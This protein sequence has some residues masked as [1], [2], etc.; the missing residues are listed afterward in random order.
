MDLSYFIRYPSTTIG[1][2]FGSIKRLWCWHA[3]ES[4]EVSYGGVI[5]YGGVFS[6]DKEQIP[7]SFRPY[8]TFTIHIRSSNLWT[9][10][11]TKIQKDNYKEVKGLRKEG[12]TYKQISDHFNEVGRK[13]TRGKRFSDGSV[14]S[15]EKKMDKR[16]DRLTRVFPINIDEMDIIFEETIIVDKKEVTDEILK[17]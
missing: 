13:T 1:L 5:R 9:S 7:P 12:L 3:K 17:T 11:L 6:D 10:K 16:I 4:C 15:L 2:P 14:H 8:L